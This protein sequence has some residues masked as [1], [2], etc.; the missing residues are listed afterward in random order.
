MRLFIIITGS[1][2]LMLGLLPMI[3]FEIRYRRAQ[4]AVSPEKKK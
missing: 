1:I 3:A 4:I 2:Y